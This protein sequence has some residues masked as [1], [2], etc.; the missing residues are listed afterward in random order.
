[1]AALIQRVGPCRFQA[2]VHADPFTTLLRAIVAQQVSGAAARTIFGRV[3]ALF[4]NDVP[5]PARMLRLDDEALRGAGLSRAKV[6]YVRDLA[7]HV[8]DGR[9]D[10]RALPAQ[11]DDDAITA[12]TAVKGIG[13][14]TA[15]VFLMFHLERPGVSLGRPGPDGGDSARLPHA[16]AAHPS[17]GPHARGDV[18]A[19]SLG[20]ELVSVAE[21]VDAGRALRP[22]PGVRARKRAT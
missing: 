5:V 7:A 20:G 19:A 12:L 9:L 13:T 6:L 15:E 10:L 22:H 16:R 18:A 14:W 11:S 3:C 1:M 2:R 21:P 17:E 8:Q 4:P